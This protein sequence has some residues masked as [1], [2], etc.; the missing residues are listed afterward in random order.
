MSTGSILHALVAYKNKQVFAQTTCQDKEVPEIAVRIM[1][2]LDLTVDTKKTHAFQ[3]YTYNS[4]ITQGVCF[5]C[6]VTEAFARRIAF[7]FLERLKD[8]YMR[9]YLGKNASPKDFIRFM[10]NERTFFSDNPEADKLR[11]LQ[12]QVDEVKNI[13]LENIDKTLNRGAKLE[14]IDR[15]AEDL[16]QTAQVFTTKTKKLKCEMIKKN[17]KLTIVI[18]VCCVVILLIIGL[19]LYFHFK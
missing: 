13:M 9:N 1:Q 15:A 4:T 11:G 5:M 19:V 17:M 18:V 6:V 3:G 8:E 12:N 10:E 14:D 7:A 16:S 2:T